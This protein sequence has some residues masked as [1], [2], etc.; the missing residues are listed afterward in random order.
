[1]GGRGEGACASFRPVEATGEGAATLC[2]TFG[3]AFPGTMM[4]FRSQTVSTRTATATPVRW[5]SVSLLAALLSAAAQAGGD[6]F[7]T[8]AA[9][10]Q[11]L[12]PTHYRLVLT[13]PIPNGGQ[14]PAV[15]HLRYEPRAFGVPRFQEIT[16]R[17]FDTCIA[18]IERHVRLREPF[19]LGVMG[20]GLVPVPRAIDEYR[21]NALVPLHEHGGET[22]CYAF[23]RSP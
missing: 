23:A 8:A 1:L 3:N 7:V 17:A 20:T 12:S 14:R 13:T 21:S 5:A 6:S 9:S 4:R 22:V 2:R 10:M 18:R 16:R 11:R 19:R 15:L